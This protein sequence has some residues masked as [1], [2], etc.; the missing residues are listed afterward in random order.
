MLAPDERINETTNLP[1]DLARD[2][3]TAV[4]F[5]EKLVRGLFARGKVTTKQGP[6]MGVQEFRAALDRLIDEACGD[7]VPPFQIEHALDD[8][9]T[10]LRMHEG[11]SGAPGKG[12]GAGA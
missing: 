9:A 11:S 4:T 3:A 6:R 7:G 10:E 2:V 12:R 8:A 1:A 5:L